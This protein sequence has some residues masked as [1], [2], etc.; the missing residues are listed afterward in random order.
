MKTKHIAASILIAAYAFIGAACSAP[1]GVKA[2]S[3]SA[4]GGY[5]NPK[6]GET[7]TGSAATT[8]YFADP[9]NVTPVATPSK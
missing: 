4:S 8:V 1:T 7:Y 9:K 2:V 6:T 3:Q 5:S